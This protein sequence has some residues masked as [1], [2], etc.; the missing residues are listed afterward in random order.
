MSFDSYTTL[1]SLELEFF[2]V[3]N[4]SIYISFSVSMGLFEFYIK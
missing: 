2:E 3:V 1:T 4:D